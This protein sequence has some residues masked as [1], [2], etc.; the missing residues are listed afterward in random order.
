MTLEELNSLSNQEAGIEFTKCCGSK[1]WVS[2][3]VENRPYDDEVVLLEVAKKSWLGCTESD[4]LE[5]FTHHPR[6]G[7]VESLSKKYANTR[8]WAGIEQKSV[9]SASKTV[10]EK[11]AERNI[12]YEDKFGFIFIVCATGKSA[13]EMLVIMES[14]IENEYSDEL[15]I[16]MGEQHKITVL[17]LKKLLA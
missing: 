2:Q 4:W 5:A 12:I 13:E 8:E 10:I 15:K 9:D 11:L 17:R 1:K 7:D 16:A 6:I 14:R 3:M